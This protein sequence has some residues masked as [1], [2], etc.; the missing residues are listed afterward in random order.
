MII[1]LIFWLFLFW[2]CG[3]D[4]RNYG[5]ADTACEFLGLGREEVDVD[6]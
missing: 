4:D 5:V 2:V 1:Y 3:F 6:L